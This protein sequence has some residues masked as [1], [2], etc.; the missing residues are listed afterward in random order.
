M[1]KQ[2]VLIDDRHLTIRVSNDLPEADV[3]AV[4]QTLAGD[5]FMDRLR[6]AIRAA[7]RAFPELTPCR[8]SLTR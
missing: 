5:E 1:A 4:R 7:V 2:T 6:R 3:D 8:I